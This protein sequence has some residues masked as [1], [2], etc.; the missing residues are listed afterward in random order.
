M[1]L[2]LLSTEFQ[3]DSSNSITILWKIPL[4][5][6]SL[7]LTFQ[8]LIWSNFL[9]LCCILVQYTIKIKKK[10]CNFSLISI[11]CVQHYYAKEKKDD[12]A[13]MTKK[14][15]RSC[16]ILPKTERKV[17]MKCLFRKWFI[18]ITTELLHVVQNIKNLP[19]EIF[20]ACFGSHDRTFLGKASA[21]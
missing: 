3:W 17:E 2:R 13:K 12:K 21:G 6:K 5:T 7:F 19:P 10:S 9:V 1:W 18:Q 4:K 16:Y 8:N 14:P 20:H 11:F 15:S